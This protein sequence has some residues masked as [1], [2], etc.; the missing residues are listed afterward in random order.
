MKTQSYGIVLASLLALACG[1]DAPS[2]GP[3]YVISDEPAA[4][5][6]IVVDYPVGR[7]DDLDFV[8]A[9][10]NQTLASGA[11]IS[12]IYQ[13]A[14]NLSDD[15]FKG[16]WRRVEGLEPGSREFHID[17]VI[18]TPTPAGC[19][20][21]GGANVYVKVGL[22]TETPTTTVINGDIRAAFDKGE[23]S[24]PGATVPVVGDARNTIPGCDGQTWG[25]STLTTT[26]PIEI[27]IGIDGVAYLLFGSES[28]FE[29]PDDLVYIEMTLRDVSPND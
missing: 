9:H 5:A 28:A 3:T 8:S 20:V 18:A 23:Q 10:R 19:D 21:G 14:F 26:E 16:I 27:E 11:T 2:S 4:W 12:G 29:S 22:L 15:L 1:E 17:A 24:N 13:Y 7:F 25:L 6:S